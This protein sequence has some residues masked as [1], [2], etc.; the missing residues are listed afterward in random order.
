M[1]R[2]ARLLGPCL[3]AALLCSACVNRDELAINLQ[4]AAVGPHLPKV[5]ACWESAFEEAGFRGSYVASVDFRIHGDGTLS[6]AVVHGIEDPSG[7]SDAPP[8]GFESC[9]VEALNAST[10]GPAGIEPGA[11]VQ[12]VGYRLAFGDATEAARQ[13]ASDESPNILIGPRADRCQG[14]YGYDPPREM[15]GLQSELAKAQGDAATAQQDGD[16]DREARALQQTYD[17]ALELRSRLSFE[18]VR[19]DLPAEGRKRVIAELERSGE[20]ASSVGAR[21]GCTPP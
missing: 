16:R 15:A 17:L 19:D 8:Y 9:L 12:V 4:Q 5:L 13:E 11:D 2:A 20:L 3:A 10:L 14:L 1:T 18:A 7:T 21:I 6:D